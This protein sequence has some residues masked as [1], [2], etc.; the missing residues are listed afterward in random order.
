MDLYSMYLINVKALLEREEL[1]TKITTKRK[2][3]DCP[4]KVLELCDDKVTD[5]KWEYDEIIELAKM[6]EEK[7]DGIRQRD[8]YQKIL[9]SCKQAEKDGAELSEAINSM[10]R[11]YENAKVCYAYLHDAPNLSF[12]IACNDERH[13]KSNGWP[14]WFSRG[15]TL[16]EMIAPRNV[17]FFKKEWWAISNKRMFACTLEDITGVPQCVLMDGLHGDR[18]CVAQIMSWAAN[19]TMT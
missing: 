14:E 12:P 11:W 1:M 19:R 6:D 5:K 4:V 9:D 8:G 2:R 7:R 17:W 13:P 16:Q 3:V 18:P 10:Y 15:W